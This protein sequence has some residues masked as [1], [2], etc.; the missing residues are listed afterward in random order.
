MSS[1]E[2]ILPEN[3][4]AASPKKSAADHLAVFSAASVEVD[5]NT[6]ST[7]TSSLNMTSLKSCFLQMASLSSEPGTV[8]I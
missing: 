1:F 8:G 2:H 4:F 5:E 6:T 7:D 3:L